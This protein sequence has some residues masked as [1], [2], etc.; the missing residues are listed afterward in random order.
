MS[1]NPHR[2]GSVAIVG[3]PNVGKS[4]LLNRF[5]RQKIAI[6]SHKPETTRDR[7]LGVL[8][9]PDAQILFLDTPGIYRGAKTLM[10][11]HQI[12]VAREALAEAD[13][14]LLMTE[15][16]AGFTDEDKDLLRLLPKRSPLTLPSPHRGEGKEEGVPVFLAINKVD[17]VKKDLILPQLAVAGQLY[18]FREIFPI[19]AEKG[20]NVKELLEALARSLPE[21]PPHFP[22]TQ[23]TDRPVRTMAQELI[24]EQV[25]LFTHEEVP[26]S[27]AV[28]IE[29]W[30]EGKEKENASQRDSSFQ[31]KCPREKRS[32]L[33]K[34]YVRA[35]IYVERDSQRIILIGK[36]GALLKKVGQAARKG[37]ET[38]AERPVF[39]DLWV[40]VAK[41]WRK[42]PVMLR[43]LGYG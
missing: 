36:A 2:C 19:S 16:Q 41:N 38:L 40:K 9:L 29:E 33:Y 3:R 21:G 8:T 18:P 32:R 11:K 17:R 4:T 27:V 22:G 31:E 13:A 15:A 39:L 12:Q 24:R 1:S 6:V 20:D 7:L 37:I 42:D 23:V 34:I 5:L 10:A 25:L 28:L 43:R 35:T 14:L 26:Y 30:R